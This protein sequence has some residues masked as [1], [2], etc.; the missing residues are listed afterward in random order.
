MTHGLKPYRDYKDTGEP[1]FSRIPSQWDIQR[2]GRLFEQRIENGF[3]ELPILEVSLRTGVRVRDMEN[4]T[5]K[6]VMS[7]RAK[8]KRAVAGDIA[9]N[10]MRMWQGAV[11]VVPQ[12]GLISPAYVVARPHAGTETRYFSYLYRT[13]AYKAEIDAFSRGI[14]KDRNRL[15]WEDF[16]RMPVC[17]PPTD[18]QRE[19]GAFLDAHAAKVRRFIR[20]RRRLIDVLNEQK[21]AIID[22]AVTRGVNPDVEYKP[23][24]FEEC[25]DIPA[26]WT[27]RRLRNVAELRV[28]NVDKHTKA[29]EQPVRLCNYTDVYKNSVI[30]A[31]MPFMMATATSSEIDAFRLNVGDVIITKD[32]EDWQ[33]IGVPAVVAEAAEDLVCGYHLAIL[34]PL[35]GTIV[36]PFLAYA[37]RSRF[38]VTQFSIAANGV[39]RYGL[40]HGAIKATA[41]ALPPIDEQE[42]IVRHIDQST[43]T[44]NTALNRIWREIDLI[45]EYRTRLVADVVTG[46]I[47]VRGLAPAELDSSEEPL[48]DVFDEGGLEDAEDEL[49]EES[50]SE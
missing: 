21:Q 20:N 32:S 13:D 38:V 9:Y 39:T 28:S 35:P 46:K 16:K 41:L 22:E 44:I 45:Q 4:G 19:I 31:G 3:A 36:G 14:V 7:D 17:V 37:L 11:G 8:Y 50:A 23:S 24:D 6:Q 27:I 40:S 18:E 15:Y 47:D 43:A 42:H 25:G 2:N 48:D 26:H 10:M 12:D 34:R 1:S 30:T 33:D 49:V 29:D 5:R